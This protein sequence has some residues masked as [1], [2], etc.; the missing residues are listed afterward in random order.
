[1]KKIK[2]LV[3]ALL[4]GSASLFA[5]NSEYFNEP[6]TIIRSQIMDLIKSSAEKIDTEMR[7]N[8]TFTFSSEGEIVVLNMDTKD[9]DVLNYVRENLNYKK[10]E[11]PGIPNKI[12]SF[13]LKCTPK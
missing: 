8:I 5:S 4:L 1:M 11:N 3:V 9:S 12:Y 10:V 6:N 7:V 13:Y 2:I